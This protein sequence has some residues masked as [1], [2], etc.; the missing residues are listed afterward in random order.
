MSSK[1]DKS[2]PYGVIRGQHPATYIQGG[3]YFL[4]N[5]TEYVSGKKPETKPVEPAKEPEP[6]A[7]AAAPAEDGEDLESLHWSQLRKM[8]E[9]AGGTW[10]NKTDAIA[11]LKAKG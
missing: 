10:S 5:G 11:F 1:L 8:V 4:G 2:R 9:D 6:T 3:K 7:Q